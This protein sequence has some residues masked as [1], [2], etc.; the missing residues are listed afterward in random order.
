MT[1]PKLEWLSRSLSTGHWIARAGTSDRPGSRVI[2]CVYPSLVT[3]FFGLGQV[4]SWGRNE[5]NLHDDVDAMVF[6]EAKARKIA[7]EQIRS[8][9]GALLT[10][11][12][13]SGKP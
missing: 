9:W 8:E 3:V 6:V 10:G 2:L 1:Q 5:Y 11:E 12:P 4:C 13:L 7:L